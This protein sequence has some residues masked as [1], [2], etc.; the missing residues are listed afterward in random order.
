MTRERT[1]Q[2]GCPRVFQLQN[3][4]RR[5]RTSLWHFEKPQAR[6]LSYQVSQLEHSRK[7]QPERLALSRNHCT[8]PPLANPRACGVGAAQRAPHSDQSS[9]TVVCTARPHCQLY[10]L[11]AGFCALRSFKRPVPALRRESRSEAPLPQHRQCQD[12]LPSSAG[13]GKSA[14]GGARP[15]LEHGLC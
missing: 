15:R 9:H 14:R 4:L 2:V 10:G 8:R 12:S 11:W 3:L 6:P 5:T 13:G 7:S 1:A